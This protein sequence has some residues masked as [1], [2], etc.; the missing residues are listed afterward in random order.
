MQ[1]IKHGSIQDC[2]SHI[3]FY[4]HI[5]PQTTTGL[6]PAELLQNRRL[7]C[8]L[9]LLRPNIHSR[10]FKNQSK[11]QLYSNRLSTCQFSEGD[12]VYVKN[13][14]RDNSPLWI[15]GKIKSAVGNVAY[16]VICDDDQVVC[17]RHVDHIRKKLDE[18]PVDLSNQP[19]EE[20]TPPIDLPPPV[21]TPTEPLSSSDL[22]PSDLSS[23]D[24][25]PSSADS[26][27]TRCYS[28]R[29]RQPPNR[30]TPSDFRGRKL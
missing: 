11:Q 16:D 23:S 25:V 5:T 12:A 14:R 2:I 15:P 1:K 13:F 28:S 10:V 22:T 4:N 6:S 21:V 30:Y 29:Q 18:L 17:Q 27:D 7:R 3:L 19:M 9:D 26:S 24:S 8:K 20:F